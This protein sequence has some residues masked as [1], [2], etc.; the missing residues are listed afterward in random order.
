MKKGGRGRFPAARLAFFSLHL[1]L[2]LLI[3]LHDALSTFAR[4]TTLF[5]N[6]LQASWKRIAESVALPLGSNLSPRNPLREGLLAYLN[7]AGTESGYSYFAPNVPNNY[8]LV[9]QFHYPD[10]RTENELPAVSGRAT[11][12]RLA[13]LLDAIADTDYEP[14]RAMMVKMLAFSAWQEHGDATRIRAVFGYVDLPTMDEFRRGQTQSYHFLF[15]YDF[16]F[17]AAQPEH[18]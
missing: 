17:A 15:A 13:T 1:F 3:A 7:L 5:P 2:A 18:R 12:L 16:D 14:L 4:S 11:G 10:G 8:K 9:F 6:S